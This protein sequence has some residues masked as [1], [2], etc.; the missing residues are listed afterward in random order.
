VPTGAQA[1]D[2]TVLKKMAAL[3]SVWTQ[4]NKIRIGFNSDVDITRTFIM[5]ED[6]TDPLTT[7][8]ILATIP[9]QTFSQS[10][11]SVEFTEHE[12]YNS[13]IGTLTKINRN[14]DDAK[15]DPFYGGIDMAAGFCMRFTNGKKHLFIHRKYQWYHRSPLWCHF[16]RDFDIPTVFK[17]KVWYLDYNL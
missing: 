12:W 11:T 14:Q 3:N 16:T 2:D 5:L 4:I 1:V 6:T 8:Q 15:L 17:N 13:A 10:F 7:K 9:G